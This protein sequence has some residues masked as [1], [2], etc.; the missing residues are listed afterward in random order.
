M[1]IDVKTVVT[2]R[3]RWLGKGDKRHFWGDKSVL[4]LDLGIFMDA[5]IYQ[6]S[7]NYTL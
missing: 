6:D 4:Y 5:H 2:C 7:S 3:G 1:V